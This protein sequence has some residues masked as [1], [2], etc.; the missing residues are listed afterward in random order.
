[1]SIIYSG[2]GTASKLYSSSFDAF[3]KIW[4]NEGF[5]KLYKGYE[6]FLVNEL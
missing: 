3:V 6:V 2:E 1:M 5:F 4:K